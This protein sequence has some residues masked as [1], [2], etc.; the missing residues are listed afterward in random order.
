MKMNSLDKFLAIIC[1]LVVLGLT[2]LTIIAF[3]RSC[4]PRAKVGDNL[5]I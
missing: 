4:A 3:G 5:S 2:I 1:A